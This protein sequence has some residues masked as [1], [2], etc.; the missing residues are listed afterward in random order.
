MLVN[1]NQKYRTRLASI[2]I[3]LLA[4]VGFEIW[5]ID[6]T[7]T[8][9]FIFGALLLL[10]GVPHGAIDPAVAKKAGLCGGDHGLLRFT[11]IYLTLT[12]LLIGFWIILPNIFLITML[13]LSVWHFSE[14]WFPYFPRQLSLAI[15]VAV[16]TLPSLFYPREVFEIFRLIAPLTTTDL[17]N[18]LALLSI[19]STCLVI[20]YCIK[21]HLLSSLMIWQIII[22]FS[23][24]S[25][26]PPILYFTLYFCIHHSPLHLSRSLSEIGLSEMLIHAISF[27]AL[28]LAGGWVLFFSLPSILLEQRLLQVFF[29]GLFSLTVPHMILIW[30]VGEKKG[31]TND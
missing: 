2:T 4:I 21:R 29:V 17:M 31:F 12:L 1:V 20:L 11:F 3:S 5:N 6:S 24:S 26:L 16:I 13:A 19:I 25:I 7:R 10:T 8:Q 22:L 28:T 23:S 18:A 27:S 14:D 30:Y 15:S 9:L